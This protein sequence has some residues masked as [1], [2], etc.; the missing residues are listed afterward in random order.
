MA[1]PWLAAAFV[2]TLLLRL[3]AKK[4][5][6]KE[7]QKFSVL[8]ILGESSPQVELIKVMAEWS[9][10]SAGS[11]RI[12][13]QLLPLLDGLADARERAARL[14]ADHK[15]SAENPINKQEIL[16]TLD[17][18]LADALWM[19]RHLIRLP[20]Q[21]KTTFTKRIAEPDFQSSSLAA[22]Q[23]TLDEARSLVDSI[24]EA[25]GRD[26]ALTLRRHLARLEEIHSA[27]EELGP[28]PEFMEDLK[29]AE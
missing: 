28:E 24:G 6:N 17:L 27:R 29:E 9:K 13:P 18:A 11:D 23:E 8:R 22:I 16:A 26:S 2:A 21:R 20:R 5:Q 7:W 25:A 15:D 12:A 10:T 3:Y 19:G 4:K 14:L 1:L